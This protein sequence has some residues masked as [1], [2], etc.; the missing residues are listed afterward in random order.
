[1]NFKEFIKSEEVGRAGCMTKMVD[2]EQVMK[3]AIDECSKAHKYASQELTQRR[4]CASQNWRCSPQIPEKL[5]K[6]K[7]DNFLLKPWINFRSSTRTR[8]S[9]CQLADDVNKSD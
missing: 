5:Q 3:L 2:D 7:A 8:P 1:M 6:L 9:N 4:S